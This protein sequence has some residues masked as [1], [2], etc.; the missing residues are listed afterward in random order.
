[1]AKRRPE[2]IIGEWGIRD[3]TPP[4]QAER[5]KLAHE[6]ELNPYTGR[7]LPRRIRRFRVEADRYLASLGGPLPYMRRLR[8]IEDAIGAHEARLAEAYAEHRGDAAAWRALAERWD[9]GDVN[10]LIARHNRW[11]PT[12]ARLP[13]DPRTRD[14]VKVGGR[15]YRREPL[16]AAWILERFP[17]A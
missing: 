10:D 12:E 4:S 14:Y 2:E 5:A 17:A 9:F 7:K 8:Q 13:M 6:A 1:M 16:D 3:V 11:Y 15:P